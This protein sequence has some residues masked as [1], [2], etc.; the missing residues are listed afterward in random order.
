MKDKPLDVTPK[1]THQEI[2]HGDCVEHRCHSMWRF[3]RN[4]DITISE[5]NNSSVSYITA[6]KF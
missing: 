1:I 3:L 2:K 5:L 4:M 6:D